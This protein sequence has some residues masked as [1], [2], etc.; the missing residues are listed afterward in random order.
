MAD[1]RTGATMLAGATRFRVWAPRVREMAVEIVG[2]TNRTVPM[3]RIERGFF[4]V[5]VPGVGHGADYVYVLDG[6]KKR[7]DPSSRW[8]PSGVHAPSRVYGHEA[9]VWS[10]GAY[11]GLDPHDLVVYELHVGTFT[12]EGTFAS[13]IPKLPYLL[14]LGVTAIELMPVA[15]FPGDRNWGYDGVYPYAAQA[16]Y[17]GPDGLKMLVDAAHRHGLGVVLDVVYNHLGPEGN[18]LADF[19]PYFTNRYSTPWGESLNFDGP[20]SDEVRRYFRDNALAWLTD[21]HIDGLRLDAIHAIV[22]MSARHFLQETV[23]AFHERARALGRRALIIAESDLNDV[24]VIEPQGK[25]G[26][27][28]DAQ[29]SDD[30]HHAVVAAATG[31]RY[32]YFEDFGAM[33]DIAKAITQGFVYDGRFSR[34]RDRTHGNSSANEPGHKFLA[35]LQN[36]D[37]VANASHGE[38]MAKLAAPSVV[39]AMAALLFAQA[40]PPMLFM[41]EEFGEVAPFDFFTSHSDPGLIEAVRKGRREE[42]RS[43]G[44]SD[45]P[46]PQD[47]AT[48]RASKLDW[49][50][51]DE[52]E[53][54]PMLRLYRDLSA[55]RKAHPALS[56]GRRDLA[57]VRFREGP[58]WIA[59]ERWDETGDA[60]AV[61]V[62]FERTQVSMPLGPRAGAFEL[63]LGT[64]EV[65]YGGAPT[66]AEPPS[67]L[68][69]LEEASEWIDCPGETALIYARTP[70]RK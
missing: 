2:P 67:R 35:F 11:P 7:P 8:Q 23:A 12:P 43:M 26:F 10:D 14:D 4:D 19:G 37:Q 15:Q 36:H 63:V 47:E 33:A 32:G 52:P 58:R 61:L 13:I 30:F 20:G 42:H 56:N 68:E 48:F 24:R 62:N 25:N 21:F 39:R 59:I 64:H 28:F 22:D 45:P 57:F 31:A 46:D 1:M 16:S 6:S 60:V 55:L 3:T 49:T 65:R 17:G 9:F 38:R 69:V 40:G 27:D 53:H 18:Y 41:G 70:I 66:S 54:A 44:L 51:V 29:W 34:Y 50:L 5:E